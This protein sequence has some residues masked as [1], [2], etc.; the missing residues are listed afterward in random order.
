MKE[1]TLKKLKAENFRSKTYSYDFNEKMNLFLGT[2]G[3]GKSVL[4][5]SFLWLLLGIDQYGRTNYDLFD[6]TKELVPENAIPA[7]VEG[8]FE[9]NG[10]DYTFKRQARQKWVR[11]RGQSILV[12]SNT[13]EYRFFLDGVEMPKKSYDEKVEAIFGM[14]IE[15]LK[16]VLNVRY[17][18][19]LNW[20]DLRKYFA[21]LVKDAKVDILDLPLNLQ[22]TISTLGFSYAK[23]AVKQ[24]I[25]R[26]TKEVENNRTIIDTL[27]MSLPEIEDIESAEK[28]VLECKERIEKLSALA[29]TNGQSEKAQKVKSLYLEISRLESELDILQNEPYE[30]RK[31]DISALEEKLSSIEKENSALAEKNNKRKEEITQKKTDLA[32]LEEEISDTEVELERLRT[33]NKS[34]KQREF[35]DTCPYCGQ[36][37]P[38]EKLAE[39]K[40]DFFTRND[41]ERKPVVERGK[42]LAEKLAILKN[43]HEQKQ[44]ELNLLEKEPECA[45]LNKDGL[46]KE[47][48]TLNSTPIKHDELK[49]RK[50]EDA[51]S[52]KKEEIEKLSSDNEEDL[53]EKISETMNEMAVYQNVSALRSTR[54]NSLRMISEKEKTLKDIGASLAKEEQK[55]DLL[56]Q[57]ER[58][59]AD[60]VKQTINKGL[61]YVKIEVLD[62]DKAGNY[63]D[64]CNV[65]YNGV[66]VNVSNTASKILAG[67]D[68]SNLFS[69]HYGVSLPL[70][71]DNAEQIADY[72]LYV[73]DRQAILLKVDGSKDKLTKMI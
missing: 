67:V 68:I 31:R 26:Q 70:F 33:L 71:I 34:L 36:I 30:Q 56:I 6:N 14:P 15:V 17:Y 48:N 39:A 57:K 51:I 46:I 53:Q 2:N 37:L 44:E 59:W 65:T 1:I 63:I 40:R 24:E 25:R 3:V 29:I 66:D 55:L 10:I 45:Y 60:N 4:F 27:T 38:T 49:I 50:T 35:S 41:E 32:F 18:Q 28:K 72:T 43:R 73:K 23:D 54:E 47:L 13:D 52:K 22:T 9:L 16:I 64:A 8:V 7:I 11:Q 69:R 61:N 12:K 62:T 19:S 58:E 42:K 21:D 20:K 5:D